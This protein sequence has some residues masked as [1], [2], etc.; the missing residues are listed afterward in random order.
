MNRTIKTVK[1]CYH[2]KSI[3]QY[4]HNN[5]HSLNPGAVCDNNVKPFEP[6]KLAPLVPFLLGLLTSLGLQNLT[7]VPVTL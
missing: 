5:T 7:E 3:L 2:F 4:I 1:L 6:G